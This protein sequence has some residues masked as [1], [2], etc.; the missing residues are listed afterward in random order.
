MG[1]KETA[2]VGSCALIA[3]KVGDKLYI[4]NCGDRKAVILRE[5]DNK[6]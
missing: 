6:Y 2:A 5:I 3:L 4:A 1:F